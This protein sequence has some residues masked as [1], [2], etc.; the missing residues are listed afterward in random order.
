M[1]YSKED[2]KRMLAEIQEDFEGALSDPD[3]IYSE[4]L[5]KVLNAIEKEL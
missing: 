4:I 1:I 3:C 2:V 5:K